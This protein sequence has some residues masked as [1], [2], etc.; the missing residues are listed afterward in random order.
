V[1]GSVGHRKDRDSW[2][3][4]WY[5]KKTKKTLKIGVYKGETIKTKRVAMKLLATM[6]AAVENGTFVLE[7][8]THRGFSDVVPFIDH[9]MESIKKTVSPATYKGYQSYVKNHI[10][11]Y[12]EVRKDLML[13]DIQ[14]DI[15]TDFMNSVDLA[16][17][18]KM[19]VLE[20]SAHY[21]QTK[22][23]FMAGV[24]AADLWHRVDRLALDYLQDQPPET[25]Q[26]PTPSPGRAQSKPDPESWA[27]TSS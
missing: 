1:S 16:P 13:Y 10:R 6:Q 27:G 15:L 17:K 19:N 12:F 9:W 23:A 4:A 2:Y 24:K 20:K 14:L 18:T 5:D 25:P 21:R 22:S 11:P 7:R 26:P 3:V 8:Y